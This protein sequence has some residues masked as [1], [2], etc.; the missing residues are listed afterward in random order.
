[1]KIPLVDLEKFFKNGADERFGILKEFKTTRI[2]KQFSLEYENGQFNFTF[3]GVYTIL[4][5]GK[6]YEKIKKFMAKYD[7][8]YP[9]IFT[10]N[11]NEKMIFSFKKNYNVNIPT[12]ISIEVGFDTMETM[13]K[14]YCIEEQYYCIEEYDNGTVRI[15]YKNTKLNSYDL[16]IIEKL[17]SL[18]KLE[19]YSIGDYVYFDN[20]NYLTGLQ[21]YL[22]PIRKM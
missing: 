9:S 4:M 12:N 13:I 2:S 20:I 21:F 6:D 11:E 16:A 18:F 22:V 1:M 8:V 10:D 14:E 17:M 3:K 5:S 15:D 7:Y 19:F